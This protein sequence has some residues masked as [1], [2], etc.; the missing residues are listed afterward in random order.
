MTDFGI[1]LFAALGVAAQVLIVVLI[2]GLLAAAVSRSAREA[3][4]AP[5]QAI[6]RPAAWL[7]WGTAVVAWLG[8]LFMSEVAGFVPCHLCILERSFMYP[9]VVLL[10]GVALVRW[11]WLTWLV[12]IVPAIGAGIATHHVWIEYHP[13]QASSQCKAGI[14]CSFK[15]INEF[16]YITIPTL[17]LTAFVLITVLLVVA[18]LYQFTHRTRRGP[19]A[20]VAD[21]TV[22]T[23]E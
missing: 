5:F 18:G 7:A 23:T 14:P 20:P 12:A 9:L 3:L 13:D 6:G 1:S 17:A 8:S 19:E 11:W 10:I 21:A 16:G 2:L 15:W 4:S 22:A